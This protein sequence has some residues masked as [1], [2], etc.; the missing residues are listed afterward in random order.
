MSPE[1]PHNFSGA[2]FTN[3]LGWIT[4]NLS[5]KAGRDELAAARAELTRLEQEEQQLFQ[6]LLD[7][8]AALKTQ[9]S[10]IDVLVRDRNCMISR[11]PTELLVRIFSYFLRQYLGL[12]H[13]HPRRQ[14]LASV[15]RCWRDVILHT[16]TLWEYI[17]LSPFDGP[18]SLNTQLER[19]RDARL[20]VV[21][22][23]WSNRHVDN[24]KE[25][26]DIAI[27]SADRWRSLA[28]RGNMPPC[29]AWIIAHM[30]GIKFPSLQ[31][32]RVEE[33]EATA[34]G[35]LASPRFLSSASSPVLEDLSIDNFTPPLGFLPPPKLK[36]LQLTFDNEVHSRL[37]PPICISSSQSLTILSLFG[38]TNDWSLEGDSITFPV[39][40]SLALSVSEPRHFM[41]AIV[42]PVLEQFAY[43]SKDV[44]VSDSVVFGELGN[45]FSTVRRLSFK[46]HSELR[47]SDH[48]RGVALCQAFRGARTVEINGD[49]VHSLFSSQALGPQGYPLDNFNNLESMAI[50]CY[51]SNWLEPGGLRG[52]DSLMKWLT[53]RIESGRGQLRV[54][55]KDSIYVAA[56]DSF[57][58][59]YNQL[60][61]CSILELKNVPI[62]PTMHLSTSDHFPLQIVSASL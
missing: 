10:K 27:S 58:S 41:K 38:N 2:V 31:R 35:N 62:A 22:T 47:R 11:L 1:N 9:R 56:E 16:P 37:S 20:D 28:I 13:P 21:I 6:N 59:L 23:E 32:L 54:K 60:R 44:E 12:I 51:E 61:K 39:L 34:F 3:Q 33:F 4:L 36:T 24:M 55:L 50:S 57:T 49:D 42:A 7:V 52:V 5:W 29:T 15:S 17:M 18:F 30:N 8:R 43:S 14:L 46:F 40:R 26:L 45:K 19:S 53:N 25:S 48:A